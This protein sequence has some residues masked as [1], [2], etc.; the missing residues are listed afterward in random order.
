MLCQIRFS[1]REFTW[2]AQVCSFSCVCLAACGIVFLGQFFMCNIE[3]DNELMVI[4]LPP[5]SICHRNHYHYLSII[6]N[7]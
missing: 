6:Y 4:L 2:S 1:A 5:W 7:D 3:N